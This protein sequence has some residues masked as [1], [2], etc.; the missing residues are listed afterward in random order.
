MNENYFYKQFNWQSYSNCVPRLKSQLFIANNSIKSQKFWNHYSNLGWIEKRPNPFPNQEILNYFIEYKKTGIVAPVVLKEIRSNLIDSKTCN[1]LINTHSNLNVTAGDTVM[2]INYMN[3]LM[4]KKNHV[5]L[6][7]K[8]TPNQSFLKNLLYNNYTVVQNDNFISYMDKEFNNFDILFIRNHNILNGLNYKS[9]LSKSI[10][11]GLDVHLNDIIKMQNKFYS[12]ITQSEKL[13]KKYVENGIKEEKIHVIEPFSIKYDFKL[14]ER[15]GDEI[16][17]IYCGTLRDEENILEIIEEFQKIHKERP[18]VVL[19]IVYGKIHGNQEFTQKVNHYIKEG[20]KGITFKHNLSHKDAC[21]EIA[22]SDIGICWRKDGWGD[23]GQVSTKVKEYEMYGLALLSNNIKIN[24]EEIY[25]LYIMKTISDKNTTMFLNNE[26]VIETKK[27]QFKVQTIIEKEFNKWKQNVYTLI[28]NFK[29]P[30]KKLILYCKSATKSTSIGGYVERGHQL[31]KSINC[32]SNKYY[33]I[34]VDSFLGARKKQ[35]IQCVTMIDNVIYISMSNILY[36]F[37]KNKWSYY[38][39]ESYNYIIGLLNIR[40]LHSP[41][42]YKHSII[43]IICSKKNNIP[44]FYEVRGRFDITLFESWCD[45]KK[46]RYSKWEKIVENTSQGIFYITNECKDFVEKYDNINVESK[47]LPNSND[48]TEKECN[49]N[50][51]L[52]S[53]ILFNNSIKFVIGYFGSTYDYENFDLIIPTIDILIQTYKNIGFIFGGNATGG[54]VIQLNNLQK[55]HPNNIIIKNYLSKEELLLIYKQLNLFVIPRKD[56]L[57]SHI[58]TPLK[59]FELLL[60]KVPLLMSNVSCLKNISD[61]GKRCRMFDIKQKDDFLRVIED[62][63]KNGYS[64]ELLENGY[65]FAINNGWEKTVEIRE[66]LYNK[67]IS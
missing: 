26:Y 8:V 25:I 44:H 4:S 31:L 14:P 32:Y 6:L 63:Y 20:V 49:I 24:S 38:A 41:S 27:I 17:L 40:Y 50:N 51:I 34:C 48:I 15:K 5:T 12:I 56:I 64:N 62:I 37:L 42:F 35:D 47:I 22:T 52:T 2:I 43:S 57:V 39:M 59:P 33:C 67:F 46:T 65:N 58:I 3:T 55:K 11:Y 9:Y 28:Q 61:N 29:I 45:L 54:C 30:D 19:K 66:Q 16:R 13:K 53:K 18:E 60:K 10:L 21:Y 1:I 23:D 7:V 36:K